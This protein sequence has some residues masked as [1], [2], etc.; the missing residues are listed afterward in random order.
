MMEKERDEAKREAKVAHVAANAIG[1]AKVRVEEDLARVQEALAAVEEGRCKAEAETARLLVEI[2]RLEVERASLLLELGATKDEVFSF[3]FQAGKGEEAME[4]EYQKAMEA[5][6]AYGYRCCVFKHN[7][8]GDHL[9]VPEG[10]P[11]STNP[12]SLEFFVNPGYPPV[13]AAAEATTTEASPS[14]TAKDP[15]EVAAAKD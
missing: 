10:M 8:R 1:D 7:I 2:A 12:L 4:E 5:I 11:D 13:Q 9:E 6:F 14:E 3:H 15:M